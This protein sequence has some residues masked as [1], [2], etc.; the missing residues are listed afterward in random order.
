MCIMNL[1]VHRMGG[2]NIWM[3]YPWC[4]M[5][6]LYERTAAISRRALIVSLGTMVTRP[7]RVSLPTAEFPAFPAGGKYNKPHGSAAISPY[8]TL[9][10]TTAPTQDMSEPT[11]QQQQEYAALKEHLKQALADRKQLGDD[12]NRL[13][14]Q[15]YDKETEY[16]SQ[17]TPEGLL[18]TGAPVS[19][20]N[21][22]RGFDGFAKNAHHQNTHHGAPQHDDPLGTGLPNK[23]RVFSLSDM[24]FVKQMLADD[25]LPGFD[26]A[27]ESQPGN[28]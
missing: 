4:Y 28:H 10:P 26:D 13:Q 8:F 2:C 19:Q 6:A 25:L 14:Q 15:V 21:I 20:G 3:W 17:V 5:Y 24:E 27:K 9:L 16:F 23:D 18:I 11:P 7:L 22:I 1:Y 12:L